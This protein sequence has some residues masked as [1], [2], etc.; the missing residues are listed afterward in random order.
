MNHIPKKL[1]DEIN[2]D[3]F[4]RKCCLS[5]LGGCGGKNIYGRT[6]ERHHALIF[7]GRQVQAKFCILPACPDHH[8]IADRKD[9]KEL[10]VWILLNRASVEELQAIS[11][12]EN[13]LEMRER[14]NKKYGQF[15]SR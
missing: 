14:L 12:A 8:R 2:D 5:F 4:Y 13:Y 3:P 11:K 7:A 10:F 6:I 15:K 9:I 1:N